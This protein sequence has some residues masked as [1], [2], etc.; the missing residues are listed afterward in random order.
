MLKISLDWL[1]FTSKDCNPYNVI[2]QLLRLDV[3]LFVELGKGKLGYKKQLMY[4]NIT[5]LYE[6]K[7]DM[8]THVILSG[9]GCRAYERKEPVLNL[10]KRLNQEEV[11]S[12]RIDI[13]ID[14]IKGDIIDLKK[15]KYDIKH[16]NVVSKWK[17]SLEKVQ[18]SMK[19]G[20][21]IGD[22]MQIGSRSSETMLRFYNKSLEQKEEG[23]WS[24][25]ELEVKG[26]KAF[27]LQKILTV[28]N[29]GS[30]VVS[31]INNYLRIV[32]PDK[33][34]SNKSRWKVKPYWKNI[35]NTTQ[36]VS[37]SNGKE[38]VTLEKMEQWF[39]HQV[40]P[41][42]ATILMANGGDI[43]YLYK[44]I[45]NGKKRLKAKHKHIINKELGKNE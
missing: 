6:G 26:D 36:K 7:A 3:K 9:R 22:S 18:R 16:A 23:N 19:D 15:I 37:L 35:I 43:D 5:V 24:R 25:M 32:Q 27:N 44:Q 33:K 41:T 42:L 11:K 29:V 10:I 2:I 34:D 45:N 30:L 4:D 8:G 12:T 17:T 40:A 28:D 1:Q 38:D 13:A 31:I 39:E 14:D 21:I 20:S